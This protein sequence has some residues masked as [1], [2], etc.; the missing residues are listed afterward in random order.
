LTTAWAALDASSPMVPIVIDR[1]EVGATD[2]RIQIDY[3]GVCHSDLHAIR[4]AWGG[5]IY[6]IVPGHEIIGRVME[7]GSDVT[8]HR[9]GDVVGVGCLIDSCGRCVECRSGRQHFCVEGP[10]VTYNSRDFDGTGPRTFGGFSAEIIVTEQ[11]VMRIPLALGRASTAP[12]FCAGITTYSPMRQHGVASGT[13]LGVAGFGGLGS[14]AVKLGKALGAEVTVITRTTGKG[15]SALAS[16]A[17]NVI[18]AD[19]SC[20]F[21]SYQR[22]F[23]LILSTIPVSHDLNPYLRTLKRG[24]ATLLWAQPVG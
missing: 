10:V 1:G 6:P 9:P 18:V 17:D 5:T 14:M 4:N 23:D 22:Y 13:R 20:H 16:G 15:T 8:R 7:I 12:L 11:F 24:A 2:V 19:D 21:R 3:C